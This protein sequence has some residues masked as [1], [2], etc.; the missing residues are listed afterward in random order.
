M[1][2]EDGSGSAGRRWAPFLEQGPPQPDRVTQG[3]FGP[4]PEKAGGLDRDFRTARPRQEKRLPRA[5]LDSRRPQACSKAPL[6]PSA[7]ITGSLAAALGGKR[8]AAP[9][10]PP[11][12]SRPGIRNRDA[13]RSPESVPA[14]SRPAVVGTHGPAALRPA[15]LVRGSVRRGNRSR[16]A[17][18]PPA[19]A[20]AHT[21]ASRAA[22]TGSVLARLRPG[23]SELGGPGGPSGPVGTGGILCGRT[24][25][26]VRLRRRALRRSRRR[27][28]LRS[29]RRGAPNR[30]PRRAA[31]APSPT[32]R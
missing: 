23:P 25:E 28:S 5:G 6:A 4:I 32:R 8:D 7:S 21:A 20:R 14:E 27:T 30:L 2:A 15:L 3:P 18:S 17:A 16:A 9:A 26:A 11:A 24:G 1:R 13:F 22:A 12:S 19:R 29:P 31:R 10:A